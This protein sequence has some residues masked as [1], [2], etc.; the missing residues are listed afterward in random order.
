MCDSKQV[1]TI[2]VLKTSPALKFVPPEMNPNPP[3]TPQKMGV[4]IQAPL[5][6]PALVL[7]VA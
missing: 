1:H 3:P 6:H 4:Q 7:S 2:Y 5:S